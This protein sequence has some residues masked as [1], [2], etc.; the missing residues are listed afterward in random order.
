MCEKHASLVFND[1]EL[2]FDPS[3]QFRISSGSHVQA[4]WLMH[5]TEA[6]AYLFGKKLRA[7]AGYNFV[8]RGPKLLSLLKQNLLPN[9]VSVNK[10]CVL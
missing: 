10:A 5:C 1:R 3:G 7:S 9:L 4:Q 6:A 2:R 8:I